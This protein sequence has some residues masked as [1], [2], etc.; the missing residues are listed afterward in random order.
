MVLRNI[1]ITLA[2]ILFF[3][4]VGNAQATAEADLQQAAKAVR[5][6]DFS[7][8]L[9]LYQQLAKGG[10]AEAQY[11][12]ANFYLQGRAVDKNQNT[13]I[14]WLEAAAAQDYA[15]AQYGLAQLLKDKQPQRAQ[16]LLQKAAD[17]G[18]RAAKTSLERS[19][20]TVQVNETAPFAAQ[21]FGAARNNDTATL[22]KL[23][24]Q[25]QAMATSDK[26]GRSA[27]FYA[28]EAN[29]DAAAAWLIKNGA[30]INR[31]DAFGITPLQVAMMRNNKAQARSLISSGA[32]VSVTLSNGDS[33][34]HYALRLE[35]Y[36]LVPALLK[37]GAPLNQSNKDG[38]TA[39]DLAEYKKAKQTTQLLLSKGAINGEGWRSKRGPQDV[40]QIAK[41]LSN[42]SLPP[43]ARAII[44]NN[45]TLLHSLVQQ[46]REVLKTQLNDDST[47]IMLAIKHHKPEMLSTLI[48]LGSNVLQTGYQ[49]MNALH[50]AIKLRDPESVN[51]L[52]KAG[53]NP[54]Q[55]DEAQRDA[56]ITAIETG[57]QH[58]AD[59]LVD[60][61]VGQGRSNSEIRVHLRSSAV[62][63]NHYILKATQHG[64]DTLVDRLLPFASDELTVDDQGRNALWFATDA[65]NAKLILKLLKAGV[66]PDQGDTLGR[67][68]FIIAVD[69]GCL[70]CARQLLGFVDI[71]HQTQSGNTALMLASA[72]G[73]K[74]IAA[75]L[76]QNKANIEVRNKRGNTAVMEAVNANSIEIVKYL[77][78][79]DAN[80]TRKNKLG[81]SAI[82]LARQTNPE[83]LELVKS[84]SVLGLF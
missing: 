59:T 3:T 66:A 32:S 25:Q 69:K 31:A 2:V 16:Q 30:D 77:L 10:S 5:M 28:I 49:G 55:T 18:H 79:A 13:A 43:V 46:D 48:K 74:L 53:A 6:Q 65:S 17:Q 73:D 34:L 52:L 62:P 14:K 26:R 64:L 4:L 72:K 33:L 36:D 19:V 76:L 44:N 61:L 15:S 1:S 81:F 58:I 41:Q 9:G 57:Q 84:K 23:H 54:T 39:L 24:Q 63:V 67:T 47:L 42:S 68:P 83:M 82:D 22:Q 80:V 11:Q 51:A 21:W 50:V 71:N 78:K 29:A 12:L 45:K 7:K 38:W 70:E 27:L 60:N 35:Q 37:A 56:V 40:L 75:W 8:A 20:P